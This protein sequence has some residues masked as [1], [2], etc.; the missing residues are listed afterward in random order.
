MTTIETEFSIANK[1]LI[2]GNSKLGK[3]IYH[4][5]LPPL[6]TCPGRSSVCSERCYAFGYR[7]DGYLSRYPNAL[8][9]YMKNWFASQNSDFVDQMTKEVKSKSPEY[10]RIHVSG[11]FYNS[12]YVNKWHKVVKACSNTKFKASTRSWRSDKIKKALD[13]LAKEDNMVMEWSCDKATG[14]PEDRENVVYLSTSRNDVPSKRVKVILKDKPLRKDVWPS[15]INGSFV[16]PQENSNH[17]ITCS[18]CLH[19]Y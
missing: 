13:K 17:D 10:L 18:E 16:C 9:T 2:K 8:A 5:S 15:K 4:F 1:F 3:N 11:D 19:C 14:I 6:V 12:K 7:G